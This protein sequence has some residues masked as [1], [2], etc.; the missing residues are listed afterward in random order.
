MKTL[1]SETSIKGY[2]VAASKD[3]LECLVETEEG[4]QAAHTAEALIKA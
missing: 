3:N 1:K 2:R 4:K